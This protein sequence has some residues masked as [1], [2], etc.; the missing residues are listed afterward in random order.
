MARR[1]REEAQATR[2]QIVDAAE[3]CFYKKGV[4]STTLA[5]IAQQAG[6]SRGAI[7]WHFQNKTEVFQALLD[8]LVLPLLSLGEAT[9]NRDEPDPLGRFRELLLRVFADVLEDSA[10]R[11]IR[12]IFLHKCEYTEELGD[13]RGKL[14]FDQYDC[15]QR[16]QCT[17]RN[18][19]DKRQLPPDLDTDLASFMVP[20]LI[21]GLLAHWLLRPDTFDL[22]TYYPRVVDC[23][24]DLLRS[25]PSLRLAPHP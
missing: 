18:A 17:L 15:R 24:L 21:D 3:Q 9:R 8:R 12:E 14:G 20:A 6:V 7:Y 19:M 22:Q 4:S 11:R 1:T 5:D 16:L 23:C 25:C 10:A 13:L 2:V